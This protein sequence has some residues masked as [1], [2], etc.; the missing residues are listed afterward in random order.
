MELKLINEI[1]LS[2]DKIA[3]NGSRQVEYKLYIV[4]YNPKREKIA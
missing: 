4:F 1:S 2:V 3:L